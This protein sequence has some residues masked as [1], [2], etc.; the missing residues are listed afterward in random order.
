MPTW[1]I[2]NCESGGHSLTI[3]A[4]LISVLLRTASF[5]ASIMELVYSRQGG[6]GFLTIFLYKGEMRNLDMK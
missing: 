5:S 6:F 3:S 2:G 4:I 1:N